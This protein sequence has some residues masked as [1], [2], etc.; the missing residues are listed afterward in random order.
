MQRS[1]ERRETK[2]RCA[3]C[4]QEVNSLNRDLCHF[5]SDIGCTLAKS[6]FVF[7]VGSNA[8]TLNA[9][10]IADSVQW[11][12]HVAFDLFRVNHQRTQSVPPTF[13]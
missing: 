5:Q 13:D 6:Q 1:S 8:H 11:K 7:V 4:H 12:S 3:G 10:S 9:C 2:D